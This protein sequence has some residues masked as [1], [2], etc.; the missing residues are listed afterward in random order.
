M[1]TGQKSGREGRPYNIRRT[2]QGAREDGEAPCIARGS[3]A[4]G[5]AHV[6]VQQ[7]V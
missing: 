5:G 6:A 7:H 1:E 3:G 2:L 4:E